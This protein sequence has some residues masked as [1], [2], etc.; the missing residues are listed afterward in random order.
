MP[1]RD[2]LT[3]PAWRGEDLGLPLPP[4]PHAVS[5]AMPL[6][7]DVVDYEEGRPRV[8]EKFQAGYPRFFCH[9]LVTKLFQE[10]ERRFAQAGEGCLVFPSL[11][12]ARRCVEYVAARRGADAGTAVHAFGAL[13]LHA[14]S[15]PEDL[16]ATAREYWRYCGEIVSSRH[17][18]LALSGAT[19][20][21]AG[22]L[23]V[24]GA[25]AR[26]AIRARLAAL[27]GVSADDIFL[28]P[29][30]MAAVYAAHRLLSAVNPGKPSAQL[31]FPYVD[32][33]KVQQEFGQG[34]RFFPVGD[35]AAVAEVTALA[36][37][38]EIAGVF[39]E[40]PSNP[41][42]RVVDIQALHTALR[43]TG[44]P[45]MLDDT[46]GGVVNISGIRHADAVSTSLTKS[47]SGTGDVMA[48]SLTLNP[49]SPHH[50]AF[51][52]LLEEE[53]RHNEILWC[54]DAIALEK[55]SRDYPD[56]ARR[57]NTAAAALTEFLRAHPAVDRVWYSMDQPAYR[58]LL[59]P[60]G[61]GGCLFSFTV[62]GEGR[63]PKVH[64]A[65]RVSKGPSLGTNF[66]LCCPYAILAHYQELDWAATCG[67]PADLLRVSA[68]LEDPADLIER[69]RAALETE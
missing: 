45:L 51:R 65:L 2:L 43:G 18:E 37:A 34:V 29:T 21:D 56:R 46:V 1:L 20:A 61:G 48:G 16:R 17:A 27:H 63:A 54:A 6:W 31:D 25:H 30:G 35:A 50:A 57:M 59:K 19:D 66:T 33:L 36:Q 28:F 4:A 44:V 22:N 12:A 24:E 38:G 23:Q 10:A 14:V 60:G 7:A 32:A 47:F 5:V 40:V 67:V 55:N 68:G 13:G 41:L 39:C 42:L 49:D 62:K 26:L 8:T 69:F 15:F 11:T 9:P 53:M 52:A 64:D 58:A 3:D